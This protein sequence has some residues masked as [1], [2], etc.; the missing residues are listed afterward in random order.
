MTIARAF[1]AGR[2]TIEAA[3]GAEVAGQ[4]AIAQR[5]IRAADEADVLRRVDVGEVLDAAD[6]SKNSRTAC[7]EEDVFHRVFHRIVLVGVR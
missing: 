7:A 5:H 6:G 4:E 3:P 2:L 1:Q